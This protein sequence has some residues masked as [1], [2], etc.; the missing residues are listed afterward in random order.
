M[1]TNEHNDTDAQSPEFR[2]YVYRDNPDAPR[3]SFWVVIGDTGMSL[4][5]RPPDGR[6]MWLSPDS[7]GSMYEYQTPTDEL[8][9]VLAALMGDGVD[10][11]RVENLAPHERHFAEVIIGTVDEK[12]EAV[13]GPVWDFMHDCKDEITD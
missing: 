1:A 3:F 9:S 2:F 12:P 4:F 13:P 7:E 10:R 6:G 11:D 8:K 5:E